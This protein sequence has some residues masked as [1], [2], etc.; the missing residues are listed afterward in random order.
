MIA[1]F[2]KLVIGVFTSIY[3]QLISVYNALSKGWLSLR[4]AH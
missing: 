1:I 4:L 3:I 2:S